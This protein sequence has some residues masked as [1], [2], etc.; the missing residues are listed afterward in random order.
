MTTNL[1][2]VGIVGSLRSGS[3]TRAIFEAARQL[4]PAGTRLIEANIALL[5]LFD[6]DIEDR[7]NPPAVRALKHAVQGADGLIVFTPEYN[8]SIP[9]V[10]KNAIDWLSRP[11][12]AGPLVDKPVGIV[13]ATPGGHTAAGV[14]EHLATAVAANTTRLFGE[15]LGLGGM[16][17]AIDEGRVHDQATR[18]K[19]ESW[20]DRFVSQI[21]VEEEKAA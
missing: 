12:G 10:S 11:F 20:L 8:R 18:E 13:A 9:A 1:A 5:P 4:T 21:A 16:A 7:G 17:R 14:R 3:M 2:L 6:G 15:S 19:I